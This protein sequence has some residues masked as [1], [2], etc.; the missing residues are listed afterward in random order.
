MMLAGL[1]VSDDAIEEL[2]AHV[3]VDGAAELANR[4]ERALDDKVKLLAR[5]RIRRRSW[6]SCA[7]SC[8]PIISGDA[9]KGST[10]PVVSRGSWEQEDGSQGP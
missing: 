6:P 7:L 4:L 1:P 5:S 2:A 9:A 8:S 3:R 10:D